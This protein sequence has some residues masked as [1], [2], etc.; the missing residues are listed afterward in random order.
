MVA[1][2][3]KKKGQPMPGGHGGMGDMDFRSLLRLTRVS[4][5][6]HFRA[7]LFLFSRAEPR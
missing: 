3:P 1:E 4:Q 5:E 2:K 6:P 7:R